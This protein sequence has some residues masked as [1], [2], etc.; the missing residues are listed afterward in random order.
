[1][2]VVTSF[3]ALNVHI[4]NVADRRSRV[5]EKKRKKI[6]RRW[7]FEGR[8]AALFSHEIRVD[9][10]LI[11][12]FRARHVR[13]VKHYPPE[14]LM[15]VFRLHHKNAL[16]IEALALILI[17]ALGFLMENPFFQIPAGASILLLLSI[18]IA[19]IGALS[20]W[21]RTWAVARLHRAAATHQRIVEI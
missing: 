4:E 12:P 11:H 8:A 21:L 5:N 1:M 13:T 15:R 10:V 14:E 16:F 19:P 20:Y 18:L 17:I 6:L 2:L 3:P 7:Q 9:F